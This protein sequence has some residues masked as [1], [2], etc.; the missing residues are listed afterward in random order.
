M[1]IDGYLYEFSNL[2]LLPVQVG[3]VLLFLY[4]VFPWAY[5][6]CWASS[7]NKLTIAC[8]PSHR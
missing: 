4:A 6:P 8:K 1:S 2:F 7:G 3:V 5:S